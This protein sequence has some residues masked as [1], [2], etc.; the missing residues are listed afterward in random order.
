MGARR[1]R[2]RS[3]R[4]C[5]RST[6][7]CWRAATCELAETA[8]GGRAP[9]CI[10]ERYA[11]EPFVEVVDAPPGR[12]RR[13][14]HEPLPDPRRRRSASGRAVVF[15]A[16]D[17]LWK[18][19]AG[20]AIQNLN[21][22]LGLD[23]TEGLADDASSAR[24]GS[25]PPDGVEELDPAAL[26]P[27]FRA[28]AASPAGSR[29]AAR[30]TSALLVCDAPEVRSALLLT[31]NAAAA[32]PIRV[33]RE[34]VRRRRDPRRRRQLRQRQRR[35]RRAGLRRR[36]R[37]AATA[38][39]ALGV[40][41]RAVAVAETGVIGVPL[42]I[43]DVARRDRARPAAA[44]SRRGRRRL[45]RGDHDHRPRARRRCTVR[46]GGVTVSAQAKGAGMIEPGFATMLCFVQTDAEIA[47]PEAELRARRRRLVRADHGRRA[48][49]APTTPS[50]C[51]RPARPARRCPTGCS[52]R[53]CCSSRSRSSP[54]ARARPAS[55]GSRSPRPPSAEEA[56]R[57]ARA[58]ANSPLVKTA[59]F[60]RDPNW[61]RIAQAAGMALAG[62]ELAELG[63]G[64]D[65]RRGAGRRRG[66]GRDRGRASAAAR[67]RAH[68]YFSDLT[69]EYVRINA[70][71]TT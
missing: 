66:R 12:P 46:A 18:G 30:P 13:P 25:T 5:C 39:A 45:R 40:E 15:A 43:D 17:N 62:E 11:D 54:T 35:H 20:Q 60:G 37:D 41:P 68:V 42:A 27:G 47:D 9:T 50:C 26:A 7:G 49:V 14:R 69:H 21:L 36:A 71:Y 19:A 65:R 4:T 2:S 63:P 8:D 58:I 29:A 64:R 59:L 3:S 32:A 34:D 61:G 57:V 33:C 55:A 70:E 23:E 28:G 53:S 22:M 10:A 38:A 31:R 52:T 24:A 67:A 51:R 44:L 56:E 16:I 1:R 48:D 6:R